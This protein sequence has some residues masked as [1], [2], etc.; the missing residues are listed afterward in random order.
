MTSLITDDMRRLYD[1]RG[2]FTVPGFLAP[3]E[4]ATLQGVCDRLVAEQEAEM[5]RQGSDTL[6][7]SA[8]GKRYFVTNARDAAAE[9]ADVVFG[10]RTAAVCRATIGDDALLFWEH[11][12][13]K[14]P[15]KA[16]SSFAW[17]QD[18]GYVDTPHRPY[19][20]CW[21]ALDD[22][23]EANG[24]LYMLPY[25]RAGTRDRIEH[26]PVP[27]SHDRIGY[28]GGDPG[29]AVEVPAGTA[30]VFSSL[31]L[32]RSGANSTDAP[33]RAFAMQFAPEP[34]H[35][36]DGSLKGQAVPFLEAGAVLR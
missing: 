20:N 5:D 33:R 32:H 4:L 18:S 14:M 31:C 30:V 7:L 23:S 24:T 19:V 16:G 2:Y 12:V 36:P 9:A 17:H 27:G 15:S 29:N 10:D 8:R 13:V 28:H 1:E 22:M 6:G 11:F 25:D 34:I 3:D 35:E 26:D 21:V